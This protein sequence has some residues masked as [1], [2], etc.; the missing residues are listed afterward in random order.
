MGRE[1]RKEYKRE[2]LKAARR[3]YQEER[4]LYSWS[5]RNA[6]DVEDWPVSWT[7]PLPK[8]EFYGTRVRLE[9]I[10]SIKEK[11]F[12]GLSEAIR[13]ASHYLTFSGDEL[14]WCNLKNR[15]LRFNDNDTILKSYFDENKNYIKG[16][17]EL[18]D[19]SE[20]NWLKLSPEAQSWFKPYERERVLWG[21]RVIKEWEYAPKIQKAFLKEVHEEIYYTEKLILNGERFSYAQWLST[22]LHQDC[23]DEK[24]QH[25]FFNYKRDDW[26][27]EWRMCDRK[28]HRR[29]LQR[30]RREWAKEAEEYFNGEE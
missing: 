7:E 25:E 10:P 8:P 3:L 4:R 26:W 12:A 20:R 17:L 2:F 13:A 24:V 29:K 15:W 18:A 28:H 19:I 11:D 21:G 23:L 27:F 1:L 22:K 5:L 9:L 30:L 6:R 14:R 16:K